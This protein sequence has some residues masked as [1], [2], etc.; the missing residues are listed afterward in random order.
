MDDGDEALGQQRVK[1]GPVHRVDVAVAFVGVQD[2]ADTLHPLDVGKRRGPVAFTAPVS[3]LE[4]LEE[5]ALGAD[6][7]KG[8]RDRVLTACRWSVEDD[9]VTAHGAP[10]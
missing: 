10:G 3:G 6:P 1:C 7:G 4:L 8:P 9:A 5:D 2:Q